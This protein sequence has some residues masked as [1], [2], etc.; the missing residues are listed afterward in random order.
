MVVNEVARV[1]AGA[2]LEVGKEKGI[3]EQ[4]NDEM[5]FVAQ[6]LQGDSD[7]MLY[8]KAPG[9]STDDKIGFIDKVFS[10]Q[11]SEE[12]VNFLKVLVDKDRQ[13]IIDEIYESLVELIDIE[14]NRL[15]VKIITS[16]KLEQSLTEKV[17]QALREK[18][19]KEIILDE[20]INESIL[21]GIIIKIGDLIIDGSLAKD[22]KNIRQK[23]L[24]SKVR[25]EVAY[26]D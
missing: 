23:L 25:S 1:Y 18:Y 2:L 22:L 9:I 4:V 21:G 13:V 26:E 5:K 20:E 8:M 7:F 19:N 17:V 11:L 15:R 24:I 10:N 6:L 16:A 3:L 12:V 14:N